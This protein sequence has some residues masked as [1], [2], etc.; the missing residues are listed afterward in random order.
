MPYFSQV[1]YIYRNGGILKGLAIKGLKN[2]IFT[3]C[4]EEDISIGH[5]DDSLFISFLLSDLQLLSADTPVYTAKEK[6][7]ECGNRAV[8]T[9]LMHIHSL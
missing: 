4:C 8:T 2:T 6:K 9:S 7:A 1:Y 3:V 5:V